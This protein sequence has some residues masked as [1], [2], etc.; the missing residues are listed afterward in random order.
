[1]SRSC[2]IPNCIACQREEPQPRIH[3]QDIVQV[4]REAWARIAREEREGKRMPSVV[5]W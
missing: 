2:S 1:M 3:R 5:R 4:Q